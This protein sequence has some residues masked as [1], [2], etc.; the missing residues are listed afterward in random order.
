MAK[1]KD[2]WQR[3]SIF[4]GGEGFFYF[5]LSLPKILY[6]CRCLP[7]ILMREAPT[8]GMCRHTNEITHPPEHVQMLHLACA[9]I[10]M[11]GNPVTYMTDNTEDRHAN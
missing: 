2:F 8:L 6:L 5:S 1:A 3:Q 10:L 4:G 9:D 7:S 11:R